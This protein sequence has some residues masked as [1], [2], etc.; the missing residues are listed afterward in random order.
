MDISLEKIDIIRA[1]AKVNYKEAKEA[2]EK[3]N[4]DIV[5]TLAYFEEQNKLKQEGMH[6]ANSSLLRK[7]KNAF[8]KLN[9]INFTIKKQDKT[10]LNVP[11]TIALLAAIVS[12]PVTLAALV[13][14]V[15]TNCKIGF[16]KNTGDE[17]SI[18]NKI[19]K[20]SNVVKNLTKKITQEIKK[21]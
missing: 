14:A 6:F 7:T 8:I 17:C 2:L 20:F 12:L 18:N 13:L 3:F 4:G 16:M 10:V 9:R 5:E 21:P 15:F 1:R 19:T 11:T